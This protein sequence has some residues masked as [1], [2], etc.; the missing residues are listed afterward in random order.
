MMIDDD[1]KSETLIKGRSGMRDIRHEIQM[2]PCNKHSDSWYKYRLPLTPSSLNNKQ[3]QHL[4][5]YQ[6]L[7]LNYR[8]EGDWNSSSMEYKL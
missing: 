8:H 6:N 2:S 7:I 1:M 4:Y 5:L 3:H